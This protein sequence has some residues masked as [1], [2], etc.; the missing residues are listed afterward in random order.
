MT[1]RSPW[2]LGRRCEASVSILTALVLPVLIG[3]LALAAE[4]GHALVM[5][6]ENQRAADLAAFA[7]ALAYNTSASEA[8][9][10]A[11]IAKVAGM[12]GLTPGDVSGDLVDSPSGNGNQAVRV[13]VSTRA[14]LVLAQILGTATQIPVNAL[15]FAELK[16]EAVGCIVALA[17]SGSGV[18]LTGGTQ[19]QATGCAVA[20]NN[21]VSVP[22]GTT[23]QTLA[24]SYNSASPPSQPCNGITAP[25]GKTLK[26]M[27][28]AAVDPLAGNSAITTLSARMPTVAALGSPAAPSVPSGPDLDFAWGSNF[29]AAGCTA[30][31]SGSTWTFTCPGTGPYNFGRLTTGGGITVNFNT[32]G[33]A[34]AVY[35]FSGS[36]NVTGTAA[37]FGPGTYNVAQGI[38]T[39]G[40][41]TVS[42][43]AGT[44]N[45]GAATSSC[46]A[47]SASGYSICHTGTTL[48]FG[49]PSSF[50]LRGGIAASGGATLYLGAGTTNSFRIGKGADG[51]S[52]HTSGGSKTFFRDAT[53]GLFEAAGDFDVSGGGSCLTVSAA[54]QH[55]I[56]GSINAAGGIRFGAGIY[57]VN[58]YVA[59]GANGGGDVTCD[60]VLTGVYAADVTFVISG[61]A[62]VSGGTCA[63][64]ALC[65]GAGYGHVTITAPTSGPNA[66]VAV[67]G[68][69][70]NNAGAIFAEG[71]SGTSISGAFYFPRGPINLS[72]AASVGSG[73][74]QCLEMVGS[75][76]T[77]AGGS[78]VASSCLGAANTTSSVVLV[79]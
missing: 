16:A 33:S 70:A 62:T 20:S 5:K 38:S 23:I 40:G 22:C 25:A 17:P 6:A 75:Q 18:T 49:G 51:D 30:T 64:R 71:A 19:V 55:D 2:Q 78:A 79:Q 34:A 57:T 65:V 31:R 43:G 50:V 45:L 29:T 28:K 32:G 74:G 37:T 15:S 60:G 41:T 67:V 69:T 56:N 72:G 63:G 54:P 9:M 77:L 46:S 8:V 13:T 73:P 47:S 58:G 26:L 1:L 53:A 68:P 61:A 66:K 7:G 35:N 11:A 52:L 12:N 3:M 14:P 36:I 4:F 48:T 27:K 39:G 21:S 42:F 59:F 24:V 44:F 10:D 76:V